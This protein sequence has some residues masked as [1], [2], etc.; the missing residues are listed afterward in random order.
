[1][2]LVVAQEQ[3]VV[4]KQLCPLVECFYGTI[5]PQVQVVVFGFYAFANEVFKRG[6]GH[7]THHHHICEDSTRWGFSGKVAGQKTDL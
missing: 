7:H 6:I 4:L 5:P 1:M 2:Q 3:T